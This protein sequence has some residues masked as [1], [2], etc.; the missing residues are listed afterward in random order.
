MWLKNTFYKPW[1]A[2]L[3]PIAA[4]SPVWCM[5]LLSF[6]SLFVCV[7]CTHTYVKVHM[8]VPMEA[9]EDLRCPAV[10][11]S[12]SLPYSLKTG[13]LTEFGSRLAARKFQNTTPS[14]PAWSGVPGT[15]GLSLVCLLLVFFHG[16]WESEHSPT[17]ILV[18]QTPFSAG[19]S[20]SNK[21]FFYDYH[22]FLQ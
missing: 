13:S 16:S 14:I 19:F 8:P 7:F 4:W 9:E 2:F 17:I 5:A 11:F 22:H 21:L 18:V 1:Y 6:L 20:S 15:C 10:S 3:T 12:H